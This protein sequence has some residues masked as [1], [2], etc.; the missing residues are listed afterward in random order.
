MGISLLTQLLFMYYSHAAVDVVIFLSLYYFIAT[1][2]FKLSFLQVS[3]K[4]TVKTFL[5]DVNNR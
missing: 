1:F 5:H 2:F 3:V 4:K